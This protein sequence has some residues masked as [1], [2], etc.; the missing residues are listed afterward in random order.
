VSI[1]ADIQLMQPG[2]M[3]VLFELDIA[4]AGS[5]VE[6]K[7]TFHNYQHSANNGAIFWQG[8]QYDFWPIEAEGFEITGKGQQPAPT[9]RVGNVRGAIGSLAVLHQDLVGSKLTRRRTL[10]RY[11]DA[12]NFAE[13]NVEADPLQQFADDIW[14]IERKTSHDKNVVEFELKSA[15]DLSGV[16]LPRRVILPNLCSWR[17]RSAEC[18][19]TGPAVADDKDKPVTDLALDHCGKRVSSCKLRY[20]NSNLPFGGFPAAGLVRR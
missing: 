13:G 14:Y 19:Y 12:T 5:P 15:M 7:L 18:G 2:N 8:V 6:Q 10:A 3:I 20:A 9:L 16:F 11:L 17:Y 1:D 4:E